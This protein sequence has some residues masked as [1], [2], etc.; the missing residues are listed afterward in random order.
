MGSINDLR[1]VSFVQGFK[2]WSQNGNSAFIDS[3]VTYRGYTTAKLHA[4][5]LNEDKWYSLHQ[6]IDVTANSNWIR[7]VIAGTVP[8]GV[9]KACYKPWMRRNGTLWIALPML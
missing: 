4:T 7:V 9:I 3:S 2:Y 6:T 5:G 8:V 1:N